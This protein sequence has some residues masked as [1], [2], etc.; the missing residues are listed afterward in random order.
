M[1]NKALLIA[2][3]T[4]DVHSFPALRLLKAS[5]QFIFHAC[6]KRNW[7]EEAVIGSRPIELP[8]LN[9]PPRNAYSIHTAS[10][11]KPLAQFA[12]LPSKCVDRFPNKI[13]RSRIPR[14]QTGVDENFRK[15][16]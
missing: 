15:N 6:L 12:S 13:R 10:F 1:L 4:V 7:E 11:R 8:F 9:P 14:Y 5:V 16:R 3:G 2:S